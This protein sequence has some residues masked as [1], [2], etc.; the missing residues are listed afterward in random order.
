MCTAISYLGKEHY[1]GRNLDLERS[2]GQCVTIAPRNLP[3]SGAERH[4]AIIGMALV[5]NGYPLFFEGTNE[6]GLSGAALN[7]PGNGVYH[8]PVLGKE[9]IPSYDLIGYV[10]G[11]CSS[12]KEA[13]ALLENAVITDES[14]SSQLPP[15]P[16]HWLIA[17]RNESFV[18]ES[19]KNGLQLYEN[20]VGVLTNNPPFPVQ[21]T[22]LCNYMG[23]SVEEPTNRLAPSIALEPYSRGM[24]AM[25]LPGDFSSS[26][27]FT[28]AVFIKYATDDKMGGLSQFFHMLG[29]VEQIDGC[30][31]VGNGFQKTLYSC[32]CD[33]AKGIYYYTTYGNRQITGIDMYTT[34]LNS[35][36][37]STFP[38]VTQEQIRWETK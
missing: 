16:L 10:L 5:Q 4:Y 21:M 26:S 18:I 15:T 2:Y 38:L 22:I 33:T 19:Q 7:F 8:P 1:F 6:C 14:F 29:A 25:G 24:G 9:N 27:R 37:L 34:D 12:C 28:R 20:S 17:D 13:R 3:L 35:S 30:V 36:T 11:R 23:V 32:C 31:K